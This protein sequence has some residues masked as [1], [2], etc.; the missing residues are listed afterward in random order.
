M[1]YLRTHTDNRHATADPVSPDIQFTTPGIPSMG[2][3]PTSFD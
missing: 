3:C 2:Q 1:S